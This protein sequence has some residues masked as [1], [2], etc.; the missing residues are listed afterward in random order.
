MQYTTIE[1][2]ELYDGREYFAVYADGAINRVIEM[3]EF[4][5]LSSI[6]NKYMKKKYLYAGSSALAIASSGVSFCYER[7]Y[8]I[9]I[10]MILLSALSFFGMRSM[11]E[12]LGKLQELKN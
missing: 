1:D 2:M 10:L 7:Y 12:I 5:K 8:A 4:S 6:Y 9:G 3:G 11:H